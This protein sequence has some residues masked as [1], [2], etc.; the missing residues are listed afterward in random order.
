MGYSK[1]FFF[2]EFK[3]KDFFSGEG[4]EG[5]NSKRFFYKESKSK[6]IKKFFF[7]FFFFY[8]GG[9]GGVRGALVREFL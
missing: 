5:C 8:V 9:G 1:C 6:K 2:K 3:S 7:F 4:G